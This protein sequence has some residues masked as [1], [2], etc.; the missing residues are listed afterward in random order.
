[1]VEKTVTYFDDMSTDWTDKYQSRTFRERLE[2][3]L[4]W[5]P[6]TSEQ[7]HVLD[8]GCGSGVF[9]AEL[10]K[11]GYQVTSVDA[12]PGMVEATQR[13]LAGL[14]KISSKQYEVALVDSHDFSGNYQ[15]VQYDGI[16]CMGVLEYVPDDE[17]LLEILCN[18]IKPGGF[19]ILSL[20]NQNSLL[21]GFER[22][23]Y[24]NPS[25]FKALGLFA[26]LT[27]EDAYLNYQ[28]H[29]YQYSQFRKKIESKGFRLTKHRFHVVPSILKPVGGNE[30][31]GMTMVFGFEKTT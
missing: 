2:T 1:M 31:F 19:F 8:Y 9:S 10:L 18:L 13:N 15:N 21:R 6:V 12:S 25:L 16:C 5:L 14:E 26:H 22:F 23:V 29:Q 4:E 20:P 11:Q 24:H 28:S 27:S 7:K 30:L 3:V 17:E